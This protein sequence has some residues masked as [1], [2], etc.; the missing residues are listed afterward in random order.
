MSFFGKKD[1]GKKEEAPKNE[2]LSTGGKIDGAHYH[3]NKQLKR[4]R[5]GFGLN[6]I[7]K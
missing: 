2:T 4:R 1:S 7:G 6:S 5:Y 3:L